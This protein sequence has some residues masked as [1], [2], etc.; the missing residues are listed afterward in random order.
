MN[1]VLSRRLYVSNVDTKDIGDP[2]RLA[3][4]FRKARPCS[5][6][7]APKKMAEDGRNDN[8]ARSAGNQ[9]NDAAWHRNNA[10]VIGN[11]VE[12]QHRVRTDRDC[13]APG[14]HDCRL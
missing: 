7:E 3:S 11:E 12:K 8:P 10:P 4:S 2:R 13:L 9:A 1:Q 14:K 6:V 5:I